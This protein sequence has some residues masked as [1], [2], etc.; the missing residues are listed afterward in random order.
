MASRKDQKGRVLRKGECYRKEKGIY[1]YAYLDTLG[2]RRY[3][4]SNDLMKLREKEEQLVRDQ[5]DGIDTYVAGESSLNY[6]FDRYM[7][8]K[9]ELRD[10]TRNNYLDVY[11]RYIRDGFGKKR[12]T[13]IKYSDILFFYNQLI[14]EKDLH[15]GTIEYIQRLIHPALELAVRDNILRSNPSHGVLQMLKKDTSN[16]R[17]Y[18]RHALTIEQQ[19]EFLSYVDE[20]PLY[21]RLKPL[22]TFMFGT[23]VRVG[24]L[25]GLRWEDVD[26]EERVININHSLYYYGGKRNKSGHKWVVNRPKTEAGNRNIPMVETVYVALVEEKARQKEEGIYCTTQIEDLKGFIFCNRFS[27]IYNPEALNRQIK[28]VIE[29]HN[30]EEEV[31]AVRA[32]RKSV[33]IPYFTCHH[34]RHTFCSRLCEAETN[35]K[36]I[37][38]IMGHKDIQTTLDIYAEV[39]DKKKRSSLEQLF[40]DMKLF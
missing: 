38:T 33:M 32:G 17:R 9:S 11:D 13:S 39:T 15:I 26:M 16:F 2:K 1:S 24:E 25:V 37:Q 19:R 36:V 6:I 31:K 30:A 7:A 10:S 22:Y 3:I 20:N 35:I 23:G 21:S 14:T 34:I 18:I 40:E 4:Y 5:M 27:E 8:T 12:L 29:N 28:R